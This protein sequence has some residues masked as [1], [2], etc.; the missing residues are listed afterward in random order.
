MDRI[1][2]TILLVILV[3]VLS[4]TRGQ[5]IASIVPND[6]CERPS[7][8]RAQQQMPLQDPGTQTGYTQTGRPA[9]VTTCLNLRS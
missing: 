3:L 7:A 4:I 9:Q 8:S 6:S 1:R 5:I 2:L